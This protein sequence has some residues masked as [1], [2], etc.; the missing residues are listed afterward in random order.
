MVKDDRVEVAPNTCAV[1]ERPF[2]GGDSTGA[3]MRTSLRRRV[4]AS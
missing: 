2:D 3:R 4:K 1:E